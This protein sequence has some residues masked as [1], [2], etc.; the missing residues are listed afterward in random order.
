MDCLNVSS[1]DLEMPAV[2]R[3]VEQLQYLSPF[4]YE[5]RHDRR[6]KSLTVAPRVSSTT[7]LSK[8]IPHKSPS[9]ADSQTQVAKDSPLV[10]C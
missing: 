2:E 10:H 7:V 5:R 6:S 4:Q 1:E 9:S 3:H 8:L